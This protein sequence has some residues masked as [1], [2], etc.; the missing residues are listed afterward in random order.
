MNSVEIGIY[1]EE[2]ENKIEDLVIFLFDQDEIAQEHYK[3]IRDLMEWIETGIYQGQKL[4]LT[5]L[6]LSVAC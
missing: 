1:V 3:E 4:D 6:K 5:M 2:L